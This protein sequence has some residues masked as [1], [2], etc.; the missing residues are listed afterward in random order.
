ML[1]DTPSLPRSAEIALEQLTALSLLNPPRT[2]NELW[3]KGATVSGF[4]PLDPDGAGVGARP[5]ELYCD[6][7]TGKFHW[8]EL[9][10]L[11]ESYC[12]NN[13]PFLVISHTYRCV[14]KKYLSNSS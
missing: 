6:M 4:Y 3:S 8:H 1:Q 14:C 9:E 7:N 10:R 2:C 11:R 5:I 13:Q 12:T